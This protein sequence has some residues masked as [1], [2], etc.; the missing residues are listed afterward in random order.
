[1]PASRSTAPC[2]SSASLEATCESYGIDSRLLYNDI[3]RLSK[4][5]FDYAQRLI[6]WSRLLAVASMAAAG[7]AGVAVYY[8]QAQLYRV[9]RLRNPRKVQQLVQFATLSGGFS[10]CGVLFLISPIGLMRLHEKELQWTQRL[11]AMA[12]AALVEEQNFRTVA[13]WAHAA[14]DARRSEPAPSSCTVSSSPAVDATD[15]AERG[16]GEQRHIYAEQQWVWKEVVLDPTQLWKAPCNRTSQRPAAPVDT[17]KAGPLSVDS[18]DAD[19]LVAQKRLASQLLTPSDNF[20]SQPG[21]GVSDADSSAELPT[22]R[23]QPR[24]VWGRTADPAELQRL[25]DEC[26]AMWE[27][28]MAEKTSIAQRLS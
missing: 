15:T 11:D 6:L 10:L 26:V 25:K 9:W 1:M 2:D 5:C 21:R 3:E 14:A 18:A 4:R 28:L 23:Q 19:T 16:T 24:R 20:A 13:A 12:V 22:W 17:A 8:Q 27:G 7:A